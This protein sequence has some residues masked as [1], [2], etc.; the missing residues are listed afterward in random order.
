MILIYIIAASLL[1]AQANGL[2]QSPIEM[3]FHYRET[4]PLVE[5]QNQM[6]RSQ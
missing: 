3:R 6:V 2:W 5:D 1:I 4:F